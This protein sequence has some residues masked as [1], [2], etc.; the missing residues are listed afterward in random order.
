MKKLFNLPI[1]RNKTEMKHIRQNKPK[2]LLLD[3]E[4]SLLVVDKKVSIER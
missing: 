4:H 1:I 3:I 2:S